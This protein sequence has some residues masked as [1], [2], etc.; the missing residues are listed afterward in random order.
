MQTDS[1]SEILPDRRQSMAAIAVSLVG[2]ALSGL[3]LANP[4]WGVIELLPDN[5]AGVGN[6][7]EF[8]ATSIFLTCLGR[9]G[10]NI[11]PT[12]STTVDSPKK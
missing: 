12:R 10:I 9:L 8:V 11:L 4:G 2:L 3:Y 1:N 6:L 7:D 5:I